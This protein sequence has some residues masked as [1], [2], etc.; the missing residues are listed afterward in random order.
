[1]AQCLLGRFT[2][3]HSP[4]QIEVLI[5]LPPDHKNFVAELWFQ[6]EHLGEISHEADFPALA[7]YPRL[8]GKPW[9]LP[10]A[11]VLSALQRVS[12]ENLKKTD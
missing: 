12:R 8:D 4:S 7:L 1:M 3:M 5:T 9:R 11:D 6:N 10:F 2:R